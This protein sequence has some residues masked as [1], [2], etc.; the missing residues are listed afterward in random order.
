M[1]KQRC[2]E[3]CRDISDEEYNRN[4]GYCNN[5]YTEK[6]GIKTPKT[7]YNAVDNTKTTS[8]EKMNF[9][10]DKRMIIFSIIGFLILIFI[11]IQ[12]RNYNDDLEQCYTVA[13]KDFDWDKFQLIIDK[14]PILKSSFEEKAYQ[15]LYKAMDEEIEKI[16]NGDYGTE[17]ESFNWYNEA[18]KNN[19]DKEYKDKIKEKQQLIELYKMIN[20]INRKYIKNEKY[21]E[22]F[23]ELNDIYNAYGLCSKGQ[24]I[25]KD[26]QNKIKDKA[27]EQVIEVAQERMNKGDY[28]S[29]KAILEDFT[30]L[31]NKTITDLYNTCEQK[32]EEEKKQDEERKK[33]EE[34]ERIE[35]EKKD[36]EIYCYF[37]MIAWRDKSL[38]DEQAYSKCASKFGITKEQAK[39]SYHRIEPVSYSYQDKYPDIYEK[40]ASQYYN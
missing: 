13:K 18:D 12:I 40:Y 16:K 15:E 11:C 37:N 23:A 8:N 2:R 35:K 22:A 32:V 39:E 27:V 1:V 3:C 29:T 36:F 21:R 4:K 31:K 24:S 19:V 9:N 7:S 34:K 38:N 26:E 28:S 5:C 33:Q 30:H 10:I 20:T 6:T 17:K 25:A 14:H